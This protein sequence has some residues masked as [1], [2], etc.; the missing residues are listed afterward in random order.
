MADPKLYLPPALSENTIRK[1]MS[2]LSLP[3][4]TAVKPLI[5]AAAYHTIYLVTFS[6]EADLAFGPAQSNEPY[7]SV[8]LVLRVSGRHIPRIKTMN[9]VAAMKWVRDN[10]SIPIPAIVRF[11]ATEDNAIGYEY[12]LL[13]KVHGVSIDTIYDTLDDAKLKHLIDQLTDYL[14]DLHR[15][16]WH[17]SGGLSL[18]ESGKIVPGR[19][20]AETFWQGPE[21]AEYWGS[22]ETV[23]SLN[24]CGPFSSYT[25]YVMG[26]I[27][28]YIRNIEIH[29]SLEWMRDMIPRLGAFM[30]F[31][32]DR[33]AELD[34][35]RY[36]L[37]H[38]DLHF[39]NIMC[40]PRTLQI[41]AVLDWEF[42]AV[43]PLPL[44]SPGGGFLWSA[45]DESQESLLERDRLFQ[46]IFTTLCGERDP[47]LLSDFNVKTQMPHKAILRVLNFV[48]AIVEVCP[49]GQKLDRAR[50]WRITVEE[51]LAELGV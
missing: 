18:D 36:I 40:D 31:L 7:G 3:E 39:G 47:G 16:E 26:H 15:H 30:A 33:S 46:D 44:W 51:A 34:G 38:K 14:I 11:D 29:Q 25:A 22:D 45:K 42:A 41:T 43:L 24:V 19:V 4:P 21:I 20:L 23:D 2:E 10:T 17:H 8:S 28:Q 32:N 9:E 27:E 6:A 12:T 48:R 49:R 1:L 35:T 37:T 13:E 5:T 50:E